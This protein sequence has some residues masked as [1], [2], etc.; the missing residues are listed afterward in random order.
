MATATTKSTTARAKSATA[1]AANGAQTTAKKTASKSADAGES[2]FAFSNA[3]RDQYDA[4][5]SSY[6]ANAEEVQG[7]TQDFI[8]ATRASFETA[9]SRFQEVGVEAFEGARQEMT[10]AVEFTNELARAKT[11]AEAFEIQRD[12][13]GRFFEGR[14]ER[15][16]SLTQATVEAVRE[17][18][19]PVA[20]SVSDAANTENM[21]SFTSFFPFAAK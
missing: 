20:K 13:W 9:Q 7:R 4:L 18:V 16:R 8:D 1:A 3:A 10:E 5:M 12:Y 2:A 19:E 11:V 17:S 21:P 6:S 15:S 14:I